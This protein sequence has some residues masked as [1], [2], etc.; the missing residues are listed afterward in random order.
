MPNIDN[1]ETIE[2]LLPWYARPSVDLQRIIP[3]HLLS[4]LLY[5]LSRS[6][7]PF[8]KNF[9][10][11]QVIS[12]YKIDMKQAIESDPTRYTC[13]NDFLNRALYADA[14]PQEQT[15]DA[16]LIPADG[17]L[18]QIGNIRNNRMLQAK[19]R[20][21]SLLQLLGNDTEWETK[22]IN[23]Y[24]ATITLSLGDSHRV[25]MPL[26]GEL[27]RMHHVPGRL[28]EINPFSLRLIP[29][30]FLSN[31]R[32][33]CLFETK[34]GPMAVILIGTL[35]SGGIDTTWAGTV[36]PVTRR[37]EH[38]N[39]TSSSNSIHLERGKQLGCFNMGSTVMVL[40]GPN[41]IEWNPNLRLGATMQM[42]S[43]LGRVLT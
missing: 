27:I 11:Q 43:R 29:K 5:H 17:T 40:F 14:R 1:N 4:N 10:I 2:P 12:T 15:T 16:I 26:D 31:E 8:I 9:L 23:G 36:T 28:F 22:F 38:W 39:Y 6:T 19:R 34:V 42:G 37:I 33:I 41:R 32:V 21:Y 13:C 24:V 3:H 30:L 18:Y 7:A 20:D 35:F 25:F